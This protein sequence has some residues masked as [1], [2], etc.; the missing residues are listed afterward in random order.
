M[1]KVHRPYVLYEEGDHKFVWL[2]LDESEYEK[3]I[4]TN[5]YL[6]VDGDK[7]VLLDPG[8][9]FVFERV[10]ENAKEFV[11]PE[12]V[13]AILYSHQDP[14]VIG[15]LNLWLDVTPNARIYVSALW[16]RFLP[17]LGTDKI[18]VTDI[19]D[20]GM[21][22]PITDGFSVTAV[23]AHFLHSPG[24]F[25]YYDKKARIYFSGDVGAAAF[26]PGKWYLIVEDF[27]EHKK[28]ME[29]FHRRYLATRRA[30]EIW[31]KKAKKLDIDVIA[32]QH[33]SVFLKENA[34]KFLDWL[35]SLDKVGVDLMS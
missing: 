17:H 32:P 18:N 8:G 2:G 5:Q 33:G 6:I 9:Y 1:T 4:L 31:L 12:N 30:L 14:D 29:P 35:D 10:Y 28:L 22:I 24:N 27:E 26:P 23:P 34:K 20:E 16:E 13:V 11:K 21:E 25:H 3:G 15:S 7:G 19:P